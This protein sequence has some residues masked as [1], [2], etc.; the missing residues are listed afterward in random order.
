M[1]GSDIISQRMRKREWRAY[2]NKCT[3]NPNTGQH[4]AY[5]GVEA[6]TLN[7]AYSAHKSPQESKVEC[8]GDQLQGQTKKKNV[9]TDV[10]G[11]ALPIA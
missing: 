5:T 10:L 1:F 4:L 9:D 6:S 3:G 2:L 11:V 7:S 8:E